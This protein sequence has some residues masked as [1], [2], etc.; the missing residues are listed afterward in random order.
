MPN[1]TQGYTVQTNHVLL[2]SLK[3][4]TIRGEE[5]TGQGAEGRG[6]EERLLN[7]GKFK[8]IFHSPLLP[9]PH[10]LLPTPYSPL[11]TPYSLLPTPNSLLPFYGS[12]QR[13][14]AL[15]RLI[16]SSTPWASGTFLISSRPRYKEM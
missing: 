4:L 8:V 2:I 16:N 14:S 3:Y 15:I 6:E 13:P 9:T 11:P 5:E 10:S 7:N 12:T 1:L